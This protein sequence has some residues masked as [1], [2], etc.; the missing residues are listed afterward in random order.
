[1]REPRVRED[2]T[3]ALKGCSKPLPRISVVHGDPF[4]SA[5]CARAFYGVVF[6]LDAT[7]KNKRRDPNDA[8][9]VFGGRPIGRMP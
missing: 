7:G 5:E 4:H 1:M 3:C 2:G 9:R 8:Q 6:A